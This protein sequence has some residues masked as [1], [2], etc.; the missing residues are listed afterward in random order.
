MKQN[1]LL[2]S[3]WLNAVKTAFRDVDGWCYDPIFNCYYHEHTNVF[4]HEEMLNVWG[5]DVRIVPHYWVNGVFCP[6]NHWQHS[7]IVLHGNNP[8]KGLYLRL[9]LFRNHRK[10]RSLAKFKCCMM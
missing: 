9:T 10:I 3:E 4:F 1:K 2:H 5:W 8:L 7:Q 6:H